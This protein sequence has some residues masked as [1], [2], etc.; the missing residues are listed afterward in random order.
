MRKVIGIVIVMMFCVLNL[1][2][3]QVAVDQNRYLDDDGNTRLELIYQVAYNQLNFQKT[4]RGFEAD[5]QVIVALERDGKVVYRSPF[6]NSLLTKE[7]NKTISNYLYKDKIVLTLSKSGFKTSLTFIDPSSEESFEWTKDF[8]LLPQTA[9]ISD[10]EFCEQVIEDTTAFRQNLHRNGLLFDARADHL[11]QQNNEKFV[12][13]Y[14]LYNLEV[15]EAGKCDLEETLTISQGEEIVHTAKQELSHQASTLLRLKNVKISDLAEGFYTI[16]ITAKDLLNGKVQT[17]ED[18]FILK[19]PSSYKQ[20]IFTDLEDEYRLI[21]YFMSRSNDIW[22]S[23]D[24][25]GKKNYLER[26]WSSNDPTPGT[27]RNE[28]Y[29]QVQERVKIANQRYKAFAEGWDTDRGRIYIRHGQ[30]DEIIRENTGL[31]TKYAEKDY[32]IWKYRTNK[33]LTYIFID[34]QNSN[35][36]KI[37]YSDNDQLEVGITNWQEY[38]GTDFDEGVLQ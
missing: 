25:N 28:F 26:F 27:E 38:L 12:L 30:P 9:M 10:L 16:A 34:V 14:E 3:L 13:Y 35:N 33:Q 11:L 31:A 15:D 2:A 5:L 17:V 20:R 23:L 19:A 7:L 21:R 36:Y 4:E 1:Q 29:D 8:E 22:R 18:F 32:E 6:T 37:I 24:E